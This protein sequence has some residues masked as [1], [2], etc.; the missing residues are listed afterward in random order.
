M[1]KASST[2]VVVTLAAHLRLRFSSRLVWLCCYYSSSFL[3]R[4]VSSSSSAEQAPAFGVGA[5]RS[6]IHS[7]SAG[8]GAGRHRRQTLTPSLPVP[9]SSTY[10]ALGATGIAS[11]ATSSSCGGGGDTSVGTDNTM[12]D[13][14]SY[15]CSNGDRNS[16]RDGSGRIL[17]L[18]GGTGEELFR[19]GVPD[20]RKLWS[21]TALVHREYHDVLLRVHG[22]FLDAGSQAI[23]TNSYGVVPGVGFDDEEERLRLVELSGQ[24]ARRA[25]NGKLQQMRQQEEGTT[26]P[27][28]PPPT[29]VPPLFV[30]GSL[31]PLIESYRPDKV[32]KHSKGVEYY[33]GMAN[34]LKPNVDAFLAETM[35]SVEESL[36]VV[37]AV[38]SVVRGEGE[39]G[40]SEDEQRKEALLP[41]LVSYT[42]NEEGHLRSGESPVT[43]L[44]RLL[45]FANRHGVRTP[46]ILF[47]CASPEA[48]STALRQVRSDTE[49]SRRLIDKERDGGIVRLGCYANKLTPIASDWSLGDSDGPQEMRQDLDPQRY[50]EAHVKKW[51]EEPLNVTMVG[52]CCGITPEHIAYMNAKLKGSG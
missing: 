45:D 33:L 5:G 35:S 49:L 25:V 8:A 9:A 38:G 18:D 28:S 2:V 47:N 32:L 51:I 50:W 19:Q 12:L 41:L 27:P 30:L 31:G 3:P 20:D 4:G 21:A 22:S 14:E 48:I 43:A 1:M 39:A 36:Q 44:P 42:L 6:T 34:A 37:Q 7:A 15:L 11:R 17:L 16:S 40:N 52:G 10:F 24:I 13:F 46:A 23:T 26:S 29:P